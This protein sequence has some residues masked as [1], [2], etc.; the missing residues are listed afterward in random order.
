MPLPSQLPMTNWNPN[1]GGYLPNG[2]GGQNMYGGSGINLA[3]M[4]QGNQLGSYLGFGGQ[5]QDAMNQMWN[6]NRSNQQASLYNNNLDMQMGQANA[7]A[8]SNILQALYDAQARLGVADLQ[9]VGQQQLLNNPL[10]QE[11]IRGNLGTNVAD[12]QG[13]NAL[14]LMQAKGGIANDLFSKLGGFFGGG[15]GG[16]GGNA[17]SILQGFSS[18]DGSQS[19]ML[20]QRAGAGAAPAAATNPAATPAAT[21][22][23]QPGAMQPYLQQI[24]ARGGMSQQPW[25]EYLQNYMAQR[26][27]G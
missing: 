7:L 6:V 24:S 20:P 13:R 12:A 5:M 17:A 14:A 26:R 4:I 8:N 3:D 19:A 9:N 16:I 23:A 15:T 2:Q 22:Q 25:R 18:P 1:P 21:Q 27:L 11:S 10:Y